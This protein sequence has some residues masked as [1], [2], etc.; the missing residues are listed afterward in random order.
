MTIPAALPV[1]LICSVL[2]DNFLS[3]RKIKETNSF[4]DKLAGQTTV[5]I[6]LASES[7]KTVVLNMCVGVESNNPVI[8]VM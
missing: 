1:A 7:S 6:W 4:L 8:E 2:S 3:H 5:P